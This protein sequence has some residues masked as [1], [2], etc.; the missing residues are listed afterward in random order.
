MLAAKG[1]A[2]RYGEVQDCAFQW[3]TTGGTFDYQHLH[4]LAGLIER[5]THALRTP[6]LDGTDHA[7]R[8]ERAAWSAAEVRQQTDGRGQGFRL[9]PGPFA[10]AP[11]K[12]TT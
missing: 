2:S 3:A 12:R 8:N 9:P 1:D 4:W 10:V 6:D 7:S 11:V 5:A